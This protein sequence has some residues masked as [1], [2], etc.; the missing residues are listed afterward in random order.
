MPAEGRPIKAYRPSHYGGPDNENEEAE[1]VRLAN[2]ELYT[3]RASQGLPI[4]DEQPQARNRHRM[5]QM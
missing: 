2:L 5:V 1:I 3:R 4:F